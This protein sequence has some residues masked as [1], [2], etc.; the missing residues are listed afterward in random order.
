MSLRDELSDALV[1]R[2]DLDFLRN[3]PGMRPIVIVE[4]RK[5][6]TGQK[7][8]NMTPAQQQRFERDKALY[9]GIS[10]YFEA[11]P[12]A[13]AH[14][15]SSLEDDRAAGERDLLPSPAE[16]Y[17]REREL[18]ALI[19]A[20][21]ITLADLPSLAELLINPPLVIPRLTPKETKQ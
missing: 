11:H 5:N 3:G 8:G 2:T 1:R 14:F 18:Y 13:L 10:E 17:R 19:K 12:D 9:Q 16:R 15:R 7:G 4:D 6:P 21:N 20:H